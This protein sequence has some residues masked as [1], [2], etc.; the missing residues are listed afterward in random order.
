MK[1]FALNLT[2]KAPLSIRA[3][4]SPEGADTAKYIP[5]ATL[6]GSLAAVH[7][8]YDPDNT[9]DFEK[10]FIA[11]LVHYPDLYPATL[12]DQDMQNEDRV[13]IYPIPKTAQTCK[14]HPGFRHIF[15]G[16]E[17]TVEKG[18]RHGVRDSLLDWAL[19]SL[20]DRGLESLN[21]QNTVPT[22]ILLTPLQNCKECQTCRNLMD[23][24]SGYYR[25][26]T[27][28]D[29]MIIADAN[30]RLQTHTGINRDTGTVQEGILYNRRV[31][32]ENTRFW[33]MVK[34]ADELVRTFKDFIEEIGHTGLVRVGTGRTRGMGQ[35]NISVKQ[36][37]NEQDS[38]HDFQD[39]LQKFDDKLSKAVQAF[40]ESEKFPLD[41]SPFYFALTLHSPVI[42]RDDLL[43]YRGSINEEALEKLLKQAG[44]S[45]LPADQFRLLYQSASVRR[46]TGWNDLWGTPRTNELAIET[47]SVFLFES[48]LPQKDVELALFSIESEGIGQ[49]RAEGFGRVCVS[50]PFHLEGELR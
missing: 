6:A 23:R 22:S 48:Q 17:D 7:R 18:E 21:D 3:D 29:H 19:F 45:E 10:L 8:S 44:L 43:R 32:A 1:Y 28:S 37:E 14:R 31:F 38:P 24:F 5:G 9:D 50:D 40:S 49:R 15:P 46:V 25:R 39:R 42:L 26:D 16:E 11:G 34:V 41:S 47:G 30:T 35:V 13:P 12:K 4:H 36:M 2:A 27:D 20:V 33:G